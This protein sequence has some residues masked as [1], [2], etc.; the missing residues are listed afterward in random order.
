M[1]LYGCTVNSSSTCCTSWTS[2]RS[3]EPE[4]TEGHVGASVEQSGTQ[5]PTNV[6][7]MECLWCFV[8][9]RVLFT[10]NHSFPGMRLVSNWSVSHLVR[11]L[12]GSVNHKMIG[13]QAGRLGNELQSKQY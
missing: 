9:W 4:A 6:G 11:A 10:R 3:A 1:T 2:L 7:G 12:K 13:I 5:T 8:C